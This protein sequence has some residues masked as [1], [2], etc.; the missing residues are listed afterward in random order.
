M[1]TLSEMYQVVSTELDKKSPTYVLF[2][3]NWLQCK[4]LGWAWLA[5]VSAQLLSKWFR[6]RFILTKQHGQKEAF[7]VKMCSTV[8]TTCPGYTAGKTNKKHNRYSH[9]FANTT[10]LNFICNFKLPNGCYKPVWLFLIA[11]FQIKTDK[12]VL[13]D[14]SDRYQPAGDGGTQLHHRH[15]SMSC[16]S[17]PTPS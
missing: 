12:I 3:M 13:I 9:H 5:A 16:S 2:Q 15:T 8:P 1:S 17:N 7:N 10:V 6:L 4:V 14:L 11:F